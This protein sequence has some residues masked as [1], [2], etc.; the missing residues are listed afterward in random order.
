MRYIRTAF[1]KQLAKEHN[2]RVGKDF[3]LVLD[4]FVEEKIIKA[5]ETKNG[6]KITLDADVAGF[7]LKGM[8]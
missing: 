4:S 7:V 3:L 2:K 5:C 1:V 6:S 8:K